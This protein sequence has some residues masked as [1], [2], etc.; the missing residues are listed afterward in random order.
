MLYNQRDNQTH[1]HEG[2]TMNNQAYY[3][4]TRKIKFITIHKG[5]RIN[6]RIGTRYEVANMKEAKQVAQQ[7][8]ASPWNF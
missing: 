8:N 7:H 2:Y 4:A 6:D 1:T 3:T 5:G